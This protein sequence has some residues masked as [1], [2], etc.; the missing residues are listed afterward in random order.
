MQSVSK[1][2]QSFY[3]LLSFLPNCSVS[4]QVQSTPQ[5]QIPDA[6]DILFCYYLFELPLNL[7]LLLFVP[8]SVK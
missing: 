5:W 6:A 1:E 4:S 7:L 2:G 3:L 8:D